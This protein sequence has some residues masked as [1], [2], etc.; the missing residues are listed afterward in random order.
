M[1][2]QCKRAS[3]RLESLRCYLQVN[4]ARLLKLTNQNNSSCNKICSRRLKRSSLYN[5]Y[6]LRVLTSLADKSPPQ[7]VKW[8]AGCKRGKFSL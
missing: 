7:Y 3:E 4:V 8:G 6:F 2:F 5:E 1:F